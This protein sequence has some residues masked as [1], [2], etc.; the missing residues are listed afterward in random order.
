MAESSDSIIN[1]YQQLVILLSILTCSVLPPTIYSK[2]NRNMKITDK[3]NGEFFSKLRSLL[4][5]ELTCK[6]V[7]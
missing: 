1:V 6:Y 3:S 4:K 7:L 5:D 2:I